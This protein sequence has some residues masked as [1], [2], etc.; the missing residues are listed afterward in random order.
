VVSS[1]H[2]VFPP[3]FPLCTV[4]FFGGWMGMFYCHSFLLVEVYFN[5]LL[6]QL[7]EVS[8]YYVVKVKGIFF[9]FLL[10]Q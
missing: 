5:S 10:F 4:I 8:N 2:P 7:C 6:R 1:P 9:F 3:L